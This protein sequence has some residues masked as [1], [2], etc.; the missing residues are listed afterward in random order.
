MNYHLHSEYVDQSTDCNLQLL[1]K[2][3]EFLQLHYF[4]QADTILSI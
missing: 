4:C 3:D 2:S 1:Y